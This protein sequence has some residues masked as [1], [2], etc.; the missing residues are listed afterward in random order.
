[1][2]QGVLQGSEVFVPRNPGTK[3]NCICPENLAGNESW[4]VNVLMRKNARILCFIFSVIVLTVSLQLPSLAQFESTAGSAL[5]ME[6]STGKILYEK[7]ADIAKPPASITKLMTLLLA[8]EAIE[9]GQAKWEDLV[10]ISEKA[11]KMEGSR[12]FLEVG[13][14]VPYRDIVTGISVVSANDGCVALAEYLYG[15]EA[16]FVQ[17]MNNKAK[18]LGM[19]NTQYQNA[20]GLP[21]EGHYMSA[22]DI[23]ILTKH[24]LEKFPQLLEIETM[25]QYTFNNILQYNRNP[26]LGRF[27]GADGLKTGW[28]TEAGYCLVGTAQQNGIRMIAVVLNATSEDHRLQ[29]AQEL[30]NHGFKNFEFADAVSAGDMIGT[31]EVEEGKEK[32]VQLKLDESARVFIPIHSKAQLSYELKLDAPVLKAPIMP[33]TVVGEYVILHDGQVQATVPVSTAQGV[34]RAGRLELLFRRISAFFK[35]LFSK[36]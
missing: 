33:D 14:K 24:L 6:A 20:S 30:L 4:G 25:T 16:S 13:T 35:N 5:L 36:G 19:T 23:G 2:A 15:S 9:N 29:A 26:L 11:W 3:N 32:A 28:T 17:I 7:E 27:P 12:M 18:E 10:P 21:A 31:T 34:E 1:V 8:F 22:R